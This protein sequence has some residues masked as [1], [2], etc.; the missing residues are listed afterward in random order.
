MLIERDAGGESVAD[1]AKQ[2]YLA[3]GFQWTRDRRPSS[4][5]LA[6][7]GIGPA[8][9][10]FPLTVDELR[11][12]VD[13]LGTRSESLSEVALVLG[14]TGLRWGELVALR[15]RDVVVVPNP[16]L[17]VTRSAPDGHA[18]RNRTNGGSASTV[19]LTAELVSI[20]PVASKAGIRTISCSHPKRA[21]A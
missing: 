1:V 10:V 6:G 21:T 5:Y 14:L 3:R 11:E 18:V 20:S 12:I 15:V 9:E 2:V 13:E 17:R 19:P 7:Q 8:R 4:T 16:A